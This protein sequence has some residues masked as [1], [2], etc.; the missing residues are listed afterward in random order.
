MPKRPLPC[1]YAW[2]SLSVLPT[3]VTVCCVATDRDLRRSA[4]EKPFDVFRGARIRAIRRKLLKGVWPDECKLCREQ[5]EKGIR[6]LRLSASDDRL[7]KPTIGR[8]RLRAR[9]PRLVSLELSPN[10]YCNLK[11]RMCSPEFSTRWREDLPKLKQ[12]G[13][14]VN[15]FYYQSFTAP[16]ANIAS[17]IPHLDSLTDLN[18][19]GG[20]PLLDPDI[21]NFLA[22]LVKTGRA[23]RIRIRMV[24]NGTIFDEKLIDLIKE[25]QEQAIVVSVDAADPL[26]RYI[27]HGKFRAADVL[28]NIHRFERAGLPFFG[29]QTAFSI[30]NMLSFERMVRMFAPALDVFMISHVQ[31]LPLNVQFAPDPLRRLAAGRIQALLHKRWPQITRASFTNLIRILNSGKYDAQQW[32]DCRNFTRGLDRIRGESLSRV[33]PELASYLLRP[34]NAPPRA[35]AGAQK[36]GK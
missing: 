19:K 2:A 17:L 29:I 25:F 28:E 22:L 31:S 3:G 18:L 5:E 24:T 26:F 9:T 27:R 10:R 36:G 11:C 16:R 23:R 4:R 15:D 34:V 14:V 33:E 13:N 6:S 1:P 35:G 20:E 30:Y 32:A 12:M 7:L 21:R 8:E